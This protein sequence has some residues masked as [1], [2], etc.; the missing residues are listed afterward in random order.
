[1]PRVV[2]VKGSAFHAS[3]Y[4]PLRPNVT[5]SI[6]P[7]VHNVSQ[8]R[9]KTTEPR[10]REMCTFVAIG[11][12]V[13][14]ICSQTD[15]QT[16]KLIAILRLILYRGAVKWPWTVLEFGLECIDEMLL[17]HDLRSSVVTCIVN[18]VAGA[19]YF[20]ALRNSCQLCSH[21]LCVFNTANDNTALNNI[22]DKRDSVLMYAITILV[23]AE[24]CSC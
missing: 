18:Q 13:P 5:L 24:R 3:P 7:E 4:G 6:K 1:M 17:T 9:Q 20:P 19:V 2:L 11:P 16:D 21:N 8:R 22:Y 23:C 14:E 12:A 15:R 10:P